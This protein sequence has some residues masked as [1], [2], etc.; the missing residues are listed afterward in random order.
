[1]IESE[2]NNF[3]IKFHQ[4][5]RAG[6]TAHLDLD[7]NAGKAWVGLR[8]ML[9]PIQYPQH[10]QK[11]RSPSYFRRQERRKAARAAED[12]VLTNDEKEAEEASK[13]EQSLQKDDTNQDKN[14]ICDFGSNS[15]NG[16]KIHMSRRHARI[17]QIDGNNSFSDET[18]EYI[19][20][21]VENYLSTGEISC[22]N[23]CFNDV[24]EELIN[25][26]KRSDLS[27]SD[28]K[29]EMLKAV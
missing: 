16:L 24:W 18:D 12:P 2:L 20:N 7:S 28:K 19:E 21:E 10:Q 22:E 27:S 8:V 3:I 13:S 15:E 25:T 4:L 17:E 6:Y 1:M 11:R 26:I 5:R 9:D 14:E 23:F 29:K